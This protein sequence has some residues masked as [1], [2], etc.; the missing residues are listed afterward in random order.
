[1][2][3]SIILLSL[4]KL[5]TRTRIWV[6]GYMILMIKLKRKVNLKFYKLQKRI[7]YLHEIIAE[8]K[9]DLNTRRT[10]K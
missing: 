5:Q 8:S 7:N 2:F 6:F 1:M 3:G 10:K 9:N 4:D